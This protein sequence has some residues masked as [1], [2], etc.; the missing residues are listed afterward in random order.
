MFGVYTTQVERVLQIVKK[1]G[2]ICRL[3]YN[4]HY[5][6]SLD[7]GVIMNDSADIFRM[8]KEISEL[9]VRAR[10]NINENHIQN[11][12]CNL[13]VFLISPL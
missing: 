2:I 7:L 12:K 5:I 4:E 11:N 9:G 1:Y 10:L 6:T 13:T 8:L 3:H